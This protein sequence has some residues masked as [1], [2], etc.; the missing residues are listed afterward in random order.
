MSSLQEEIE[1]QTDHSQPRHFLQTWAGKEYMGLLT[2][3]E[4]L[5]SQQRQGKSLGRK[6]KEVKVSEDDLVTLVEQR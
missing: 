4:W 3:L 5:E 1:L 6:I 2:N